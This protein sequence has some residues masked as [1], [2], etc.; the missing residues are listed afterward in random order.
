MAGL[1]NYK[2]NMNTI[3][4]MALRDGEVDMPRDYDD[5][6]QLAYRSIRYRHNTSEWVYY[7][8]PVG[9]QEYMVLFKHS[10]LREVIRHTNEVHRINDQVSPRYK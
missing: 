10:D 7:Q 6:N 1:I 9:D 2:F 4:W 5:W 3:Q 8:R